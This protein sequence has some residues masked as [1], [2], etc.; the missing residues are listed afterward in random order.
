ML[1]IGEFRWRM[2]MGIS[3]S[4]LWFFSVWNFVIKNIIMINKGKALYFKNILLGPSTLPVEALFAD[5]RH[6]SP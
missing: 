3:F 4:I 2:Y 6:S 5:P 1:L